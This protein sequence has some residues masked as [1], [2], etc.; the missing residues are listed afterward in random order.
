MTTLHT[1]CFSPLILS[2]MFSSVWETFK[3]PTLH[4]AMQCSL[5]SNNFY[6]GGFIHVKGRQVLVKIVSLHSILKC[7]NK[8]DRWLW[9]IIILIDKHLNRPLLSSKNPHFQ[10]QVKCTTF[11]VKMSFIC[12][13]MKN[14][15]HVKGQAPEVSF[16]RPWGNSEMAYYSSYTA[17][18]TLP[19]PKT[20]RDFQHG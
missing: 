2:P 4:W 8:T 10:N 3:A 9:I 6:M 1:F 18:C 20:W 17:Q 13:R 12:M 19:G 16:I 5:H 14:H 11:L 15:F 7:A